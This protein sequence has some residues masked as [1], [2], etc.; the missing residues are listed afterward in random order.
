MLS[1]KRVMSMVLTTLLEPGG[2]WMC[3]CECM[4]GWICVVWSLT[5]PLL[6]VFIKVSCN[7]MNVINIFA[8]HK[9]REKPDHISLMGTGR[10]P[11]ARG[12]HREVG[13]RWQ[14]WDP[15]CPSVVLWRSRSPL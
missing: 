7:K 5:A 9:V 3:V 11:G 1:Q 14:A 2:G 15:A 13:W 12:E 10:V 8:D 4:S 6:C